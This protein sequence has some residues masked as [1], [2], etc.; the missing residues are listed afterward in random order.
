MRDAFGWLLGRLA[1]PGVQAVVVVAAHVEEVDGARVL[2]PSDGRAI[3]LERELVAPAAALGTDHALTIVVVPRST[4]G[5]A[6]DGAAF[7][8]V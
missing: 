2:Y 5:G 6:P 7:A 3:D 8:P 4:V 1:R